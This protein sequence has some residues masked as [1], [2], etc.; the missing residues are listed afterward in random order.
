[1]NT[2]VT[3]LTAQSEAVLDVLPVGVMPRTALA[4]S[5]ST[6]PAL[7]AGGSWHA[8]VMT[9][10]RQLVSSGSPLEPEIG[11]SRA[12]RAGPYVCVAGT[13]PIAE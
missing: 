10:F 1:M 7:A 12:V 6:A 2:D 9:S 4:S 13:A 5:S 3:P 8:A 11:L